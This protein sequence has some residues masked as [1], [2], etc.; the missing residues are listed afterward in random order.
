MKNSIHYLLL[1]TLLS[2]FNCDREIANATGKCD[3][4]KKKSNQCM[5]A[6]VLACEQTPDAERY[7]RQGINICTNI[8]GYV[9]MIQAFCDVPYECK[10]APK[11]R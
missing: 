4:E 1:F 6:S 5:L 9:F 8:D 7:R 10:P 11:N 2:F 3:R